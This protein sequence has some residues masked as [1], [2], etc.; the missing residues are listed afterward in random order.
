MLDAA[1]EEPEAVSN[2][3]IVRVIDA[4][5]SQRAVEDRCRSQCM[6]VSFR[7]PGSSNAGTLTSVSVD[8]RISNPHG[9]HAEEV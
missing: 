8:F 5:Y 6:C 9:E 4:Y 1:F 7:R 3:N 2:G